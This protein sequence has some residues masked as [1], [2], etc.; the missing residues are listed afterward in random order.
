MAIARGIVQLQEKYQH[1]VAMV[2]HG[3]AQQKKDPEECDLPPPTQ[4]AFRPFPIT[5]VLG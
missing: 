4:V 3:V 5:G 1:Q 2:Y